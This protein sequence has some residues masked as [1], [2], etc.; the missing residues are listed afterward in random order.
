[1]AD[2]TQR[3]LELLR[4]LLE[5]RRGYAGV[6]DVLAWMDGHGPS[7]LP[8]AARAALAVEDQ[9]RFGAYLASCVVLVIQVIAAGQRPMPHQLASIRKRLRLCNQ[10][11]TASC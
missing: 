8:H 9:D 6:A 5:E 1:M 11:V 4:S 2:A 10:A 3:N 7:D